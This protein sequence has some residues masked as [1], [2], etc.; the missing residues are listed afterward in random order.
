MSSGSNDTFYSLYKSLITPAQEQSPWWVVLVLA[1]KNFKSILKLISIIIPTF[2]QQYTKIE[3][4]IIKTSI[5]KFEFKKLINNIYSNEL[6]IYNI[7]NIPK[8]LIL[9]LNK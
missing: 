3:F 2:H 1:H 6:R 8:L 9:I 4:Q 7:E 5:I